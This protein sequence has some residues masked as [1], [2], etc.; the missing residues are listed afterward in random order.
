MNTVASLP[1]AGLTGLPPLFP[2]SGVLSKSYYAFQAMESVK[3]PIWDGTKMSLVPNF[4]WG[5][6]VAMA[7]R[8]SRSP[9][10]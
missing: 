9:A 4:S 10:G 2:D 8:T 3:P 6:R 1:G 5:G 7:P